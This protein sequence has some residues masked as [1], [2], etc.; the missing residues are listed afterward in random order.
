MDRIIKFRAWDGE[1]MLENVV[2][3][4]DEIWDYDKE[5][6]AHFTLWF[7]TPRPLSQ[8][9]VMQFTGIKDKNGKEIYE[10]DVVSV[11]GYNF[12]VWYTDTAFRLYPRDDK[13]ANYDEAQQEWEDGTMDNKRNNIQ[14]IGH[15][16]EKKFK[17]MWSK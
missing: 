10:G 16:F 14:V 13:S 3:G 1:K 6:R 12:E 2:V 5:K 8:N 9:D 4:D 17:S 11:N 7:N 15:I